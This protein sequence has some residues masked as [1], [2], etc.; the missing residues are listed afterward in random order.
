MNECKL[1]DGLS[2]NLI[3][4]KLISC[5]L[6]SIINGCTTL[7]HMIYPPGNYHRRSHLLLSGRAYRTFRQH[8]GRVGSDLQQA[9]EEH[10]QPTHPQPGRGRHLIHRLL[11]AV[12]GHRIRFATRL[13]LRR[14]LVSSQVT[15]Y[16]LYLRTR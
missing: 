9:D 2:E 6:I 8:L 1:N 15:T 12:Y 14:H 7:M 13:A 16:L 5:L 3:L 10:D 4:L 11:R